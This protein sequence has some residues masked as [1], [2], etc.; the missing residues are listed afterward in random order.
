MDEKDR[1]AAHSSPV[2]VTYGADEID[3]VRRVGWSVSVTG[4]A[5]AVCG[6]G[7]IASYERRLRPWV[8][9]M[10]DTVITS[11]PDIVTGI[12]LLE[13]QAPEHS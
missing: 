7:R 8:E 11:D 10:M 5:R 12:R 3:P 9:G 2:V 4:L 1:L 6:P 13:R